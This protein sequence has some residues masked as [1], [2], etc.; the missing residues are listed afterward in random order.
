MPNK[1]TSRLTGNIQVNK[2]ANIITSWSEGV[3]ESPYAASIIRLCAVYESKQRGEKKKTGARCLT[4]KL[5]HEG[6][7]ESPY[8]GPPP[9]KKNK[10]K[11]TRFQPSAA[12]GA[13]RRPEDPVGFQ[14]A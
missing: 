14:G 5:S 12:P 8:E 6:V 2:Q 4:Q 11:K 9:K 7:M 1:A 10:T 3:I 13:L